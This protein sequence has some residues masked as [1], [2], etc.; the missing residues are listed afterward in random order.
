[1]GT[2][3]ILPRSPLSK[4]SLSALKKLNRKKAGG[5][6]S[7]DT[8]QVSSNLRSPVSV[9]F[10]L[11]T[12]TSP[13]PKPSQVPPGWSYSNEQTSPSPYDRPKGILRKNEKK[14]IDENQLRTSIGSLLYADS[15]SSQ[16]RNEHKEQ[17]NHS[18]ISGRRLFQTFTPS[19]SPNSSTRS[20][21][22]EQ[23]TI[24][25]N[26]NSFD[27]KP[28][29]YSKKSQSEPS[30]RRSA[31]TH[32]AI[33][34]A[35]NIK[36]RLF[37]A[38][39]PES[40]PEYGMSLERTNSFY[41]FPDNLSDNFDR[42]ANP[43][44]EAGS[45]SQEG[46]YD[47]DSPSA[48]NGYPTLVTPPTPL[49]EWRQQAT[50]EVIA[51]FWDD[52]TFQNHGGRNGNAPSEEDPW[53]WRSYSKAS[54]VDLNQGRND[55]GKENESAF[56]N[57]AH[58]KKVK[59]KKKKNRSNQ[60]H[61]NDLQFPDYTEFADDASHEGYGCEYNPD[62]EL[63][64]YMDK[65]CASFQDALMNGIKAFFVP[66]PSASSDRPSSSV[67]SSPRNNR[68]GIPKTIA[69][70]KVYEHDLRIARHYTSFDSQYDDFNKR[71]QSMYR[72]QGGDGE[73]RMNRSHDEYDR[74]EGRL[75]SLSS[76]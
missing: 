13:G 64:N 5:S 30:I 14:N 47:Y 46:N 26:R 44:Q 20:S 38:R 34:P 27:P 72:S 23:D 15:N 18:P 8:K 35:K 3:K 17:T 36:S 73:I 45:M 29:P 58:L 74:H 25:Q 32:R 52:T 71:H 50:K 51:S 40:P 21:N 59:R 22:K 42:L 9:T 7:D 1:M 41:Q 10:D 53:I 62:S 61:G 16:N 65:G 68:S 11:N 37:P 2:K 60:Y 4:L 76:W 66:T 28:F 39:S 31:Q 33:F 54:T 19:A 56:S 67:P 49:S 70:K 55:M 69:S 24:E 48:T 63:F 57:Q 6:I 12:Q 43:A 75:V